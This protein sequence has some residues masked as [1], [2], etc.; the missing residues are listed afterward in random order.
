MHR[1]C[2]QQARRGGPLCPPSC[3]HETS[4]AQT[5]KAGDVDSSVL[6]GVHLWP[7][8]FAV[9]LAQAGK[10][11]PPKRRVLYCGQGAWALA[12]F[13][14][15]WVPN[16]GEKEKN[17]LPRERKAFGVSGFG[18]RGRQ[19]AKAFF[20]FSPGNYLRCKKRAK[21]HTPR[22]AAIPGF[23]MDAPPTRAR[24][25]LALRSSVVPT[26]GGGASPGCFGQCRLACP[27]SNRSN[28]QRITRNRQAAL[29][30]SCV[31]FA[32]SAAR[33]PGSLSRCVFC[34]ARRG[35]F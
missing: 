27:Q 31:F 25:V 26:G 10:P 13:C 19:P 18:T 33:R 15:P 12:R 9:P 29:S 14:A 28:R 4:P 6:I 20:P 34:A 17:A 23:L 24:R 22:R 1:A 7:I 8:P 32:V 5:K 21:A 11:V 35:V 3:T 30:P 16:A 2:I